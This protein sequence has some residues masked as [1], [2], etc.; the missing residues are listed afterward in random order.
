[1]A[2]RSFLPILITSLIVIASCGK[3]GPI[4]PPLLRVPQAVEN[5]VLAQRGAALLLT[6]T[7]PSAYVDGNP[8]G[9]VSEVEIW[10]IKEDRRAEGSA[11]TWTAEQFESKGVLLV[12]VSQ[13][14]FDSLRPAGAKTG[15]ELTY[16]YAL[17]NEDI[18]RKV[19][20]FSLRVRDLKKRASAF[21]QPVSQEA[22]TPLAPP[23]NVRAVVFEDHIQVSW[24]SPE[25]AAAET[26]SPASIGYNIYR[27]E[28]EN[29]PSRLNTAP[30]KTTEFPDKGFSSGRTYRYFIRT[31]LESAPRVESEN[32]EAA[33]AI[34][35]DVFPPAPPAGLTAVVGPGY[36]ALSWQAG[37]E[38]DLAGYSVWRRE[39]DE[40]DFIQLARL[41]AT[42]SSYSDAKVEK[43]RKYEYAITAL[44]S[45]GN[46]S[47][48][49]ATALGIARDDSPE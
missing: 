25:Q 36:I 12:Q 32:S 47:Q 19:L 7:N 15:S 9:E 43:G 24:E 14:R 39:Q 41:P 48:K 5:L 28:G 42:D 8:L 3:K 11:K 23:R 20:T 1:M 17:A 33:E 26:A 40:G 44:D 29:P 38:S 27:S 35:K 31:A 16:S 21:A 37:R 6:W 18:G 45:A 2:R 10:L 4:Q 34:A 49:S 30:V 22:R 13:D 46:E